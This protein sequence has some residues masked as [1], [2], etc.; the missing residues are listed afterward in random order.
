MLPT[1][2]VSMASKASLWILL[3]SATVGFLLPVP[4]G[5]AQAYG[6]W[7]VFRA[8]NG[9]SVQYPSDLFSISQGDQSSQ[10]SVFTTDDGRARLNI[11]EVRNE[12]NERPAQYLKRVFPGDRG[13]LDY[14]RVAPNFFAVSEN[15]GAR[16]FYRRCNFVDRSIHCI[17]L[18]YPRLEKL[19]WDGIV[20]RIS[21][22]LRPR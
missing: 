14:D 15:K 12:R 6:R 20:T 9:T 17:D 11:F 5:K 10:D 7:S 19:A 1:A 18:S 22:T 4:D 21:L 16:I 2:L 3:G 13:R 8:I